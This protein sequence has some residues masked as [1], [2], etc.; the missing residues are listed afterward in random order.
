MHFNLL[1]L[2]RNPP[3]HSYHSLPGGSRP[4][5]RAKPVPSLM[6]RVFLT[7]VSA[8]MGLKGAGCTGGSP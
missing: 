3:I 8:W 7:Q 6:Q 4:P 5:L 1:H 2:N